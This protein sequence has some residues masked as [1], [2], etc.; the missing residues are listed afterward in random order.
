MFNPY[1]NGLQFY[2]QYH[3]TVEYVK[4][5]ETLTDNADGNTEPSYVLIYIKGVE[6]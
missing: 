2:V 5:G 6:T 1:N 4:F 3:K